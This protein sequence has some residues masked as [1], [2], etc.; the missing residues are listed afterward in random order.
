[1]IPILTTEAMRRA[2]ARAVARRGVDALVRDGR[3]YPTR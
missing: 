3:R 2:D 1:M